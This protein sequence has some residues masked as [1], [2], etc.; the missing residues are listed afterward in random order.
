MVA[1]QDYRRL[2]QSVTLKIF[3][4]ILMNCSIFAGYSTGADWF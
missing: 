4:L 2:N 1:G 3:V